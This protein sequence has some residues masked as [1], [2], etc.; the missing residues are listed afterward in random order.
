MKLLVD[1]GVCSPRL[2]RLLLAGCSHCKGLVGRLV[3]HDARAG[4]EQIWLACCSCNAR[5]RGGPLAHIE[6]P[7]RASYPLWSEDLD[8]NPRPEE[9]ADIIH[10][11]KPVSLTELLHE[12][13]RHRIL[14][15]VQREFSIGGYVVGSG[16]AESDLAEL[17]RV[18]GVGKYAALEFEDG[19]ARLL[20]FEKDSVRILTPHRRGDRLDLSDRTT[21]QIASRE[22]SP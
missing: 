16:I 22:Q 21:L 19:A 4:G 13:P 17:A 15:H 6:H 10:S 9:L 2:D 5:L 8:E 14:A 3:R 11:A 12:L 18:A 7:R 1:W 20:R